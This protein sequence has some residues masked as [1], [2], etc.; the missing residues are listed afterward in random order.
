MDY[1]RTP[2]NEKRSTKLTLSQIERLRLDYEKYQNYNLVGRIYHVSGV[3]IKYWINENTRR[4][5]IRRSVEIRKQKMQDP[6]YRAKKHKIMNDAQ[7]LMRRTKPLFR[8]WLF[9]TQR[10]Y[11]INNKNKIDELKR[12][13]RLNN[14]EHINKLYRENYHKRNN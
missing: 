10:I 6:N 4:E 12:K 3:T 1:P 2:H 5:H 11:R 8:Q 14:R 9:E 13:W 7:E